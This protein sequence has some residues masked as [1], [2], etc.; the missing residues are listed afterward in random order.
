MV[1]YSQNYTYASAEKVQG[2]NEVWDM[3]FQNE[4]FGLLLRGKINK[5]V[6]RFVILI[7]QVE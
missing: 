1:L 4:I 2:G 6:V 5:I 3:F 7:N